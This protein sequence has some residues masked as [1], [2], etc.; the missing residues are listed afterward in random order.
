MALPPVRINIVSND[1]GDVMAQPG[2]GFIYRNNQIIHWEIFTDDIVFAQ[3]G[4]R[5]RPASP[6]V[7]AWPDGWSVVLL[8]SKVCEINFNAPVGT[9]SLYQYDIVWNQVTTGSIT[10][11]TRPRAYEDDVKDTDP[12]ISNQN[13]P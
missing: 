4:I 10:R 6:G 12:D 3:E 11:V 5:P 13:Q 7:D 1:K 2:L 8:T 9:K